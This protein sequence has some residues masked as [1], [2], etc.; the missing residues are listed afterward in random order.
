MVYDTNIMFSVWYRWQFCTQSISIAA[1]HEVLKKYSL[2]W[3]AECDIFDKYLLWEG[4]FP[5]HH[6]LFSDTFLPRIIELATSSSDRQTK[7]AACELLHS[8]VLYMIGRGAQKPAGR[9]GK[10]KEPM[11]RLYAKIMPALLQLA[12]DVEQVFYIGLI[13]SLT[14]GNHI[15][16]PRY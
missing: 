4:H 5:T 3:H 6:I 12:C 2:R 13:I 8:L 15:P 7:V 11:D 16:F 14:L 10:P 1:D 9:A